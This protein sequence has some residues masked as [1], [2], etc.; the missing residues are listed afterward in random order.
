MELMECN[1]TDLVIEK[2]GNIPEK[3]I[4]YVVRETL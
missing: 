1:L 3:L 4:A 2:A